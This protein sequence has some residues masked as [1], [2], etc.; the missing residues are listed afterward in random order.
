MSTPPILRDQTGVKGDDLV[1]MV[2]ARGLGK[3]AKHLAKEYQERE[4]TWGVK[5]IILS[6]DNVGFLSA[7]FSVVR[8][9]IEIFKVTFLTSPKISKLSEST[10]FVAVATTPHAALSAI[11][12]GRYV[13]THGLRKPEKTID[14]SLDFVAE[15]GNV[16]EGI[17]YV[18][19]AT[20]AVAPKAA[21]FLKFC[22]PLGI[23]ATFISLINLPIDAKG[24]FRTFEAIDSVE[25]DKSPY[26]AAFIERFKFK[27]SSHVL[28]TSSTIICFVAFAILF[29]GAPYF[30]LPSVLLMALG[31]T[32][33][34]ARIIVDS[35]ATQLFHERLAQLTKEAAAA[36]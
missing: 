20:M 9:V 16:I 13:L 18:G 21:P 34:L 11:E 30:L 15:S 25:A 8:S 26:K 6:R 27:I 33:N 3:L 29:F 35:Y 23:A 22:G 7:V 2:N 5:Q 14:A 10:K 28:N 31:L 19:E 4:A 17:G 1:A 32:L 12:K 24:V 36:A